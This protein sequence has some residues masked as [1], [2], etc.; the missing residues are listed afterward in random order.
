MSHVQLFECHPLQLDLLL[1]TYEVTTSLLNKN[2]VMMKAGPSGTSVYLR[3]AA[4][5]YKAFY[6]S[7]LLRLKNTAK[8]TYNSTLAISYY[9]SYGHPSLQSCM[10]YNEEEL[11]S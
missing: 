6:T 2:H 7:L 3:D 5:A 9:V 11:F 10:M 4:K 1:A 8:A